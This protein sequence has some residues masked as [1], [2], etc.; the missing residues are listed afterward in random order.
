MDQS[1]FAS[2]QN[3]FEYLIKG[4]LQNSYVAFKSFLILN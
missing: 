1:Q 3:H 2:R 4:I